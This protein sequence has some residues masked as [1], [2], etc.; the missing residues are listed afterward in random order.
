MEKK[1]EQRNAR[2]ICY[3]HVS[4][5]NIGIITGKPMTKIKI[6]REAG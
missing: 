3:V 5:H 1:G 4:R 2:T 6:V